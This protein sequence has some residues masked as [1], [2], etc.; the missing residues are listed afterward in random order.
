MAQRL[1]VRRDKRLEE[2]EAA[3]RE[4]KIARVVAASR[5]IHAVYQPILDLRTGEAVGVE[6]L[7][8]FPAQ[9]V[10]SPDQW[11]AEAA[12]VGLGTEVEMA[13]LR[14][15]LERLPRLPP[16]LYMSLNASPTTMMSPEFATMVAEIAAERIV[17]EVTEHSE[18][19]DYGSFGD[20]VSKLRSNGVRLAVDDAGAG[21][22]SFLHIL[23]VQP[24]IIKLDVA[25]T[26]GIDKDPARQALGSALLTF[27]LDAF[28]AGL[29]AEGIETERELTTLKA[30]GYPFGQGYHL[31]KPASA[32]EVRL[33]VH[34]SEAH[35]TGAGQAR[36]EDLLVEVGATQITVETD[37]WAE[38]LMTASRTGAVAG[39]E[40][41]RA[42]RKLVEAGFDLAGRLHATG[43]RNLHG[44]VDEDDHLA[45][46]ENNSI[47]NV[48]SRE[49]DRLNGR[50]RRKGNRIDAADRSGDAETD[51]HPQTTR[52]WITSPS[53]TTRSSVGDRP[54]R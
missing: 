38:E 33:Q 42:N 39:P 3:Q 37:E 20:S 51:R 2:I 54:P 15:A 31:G 35:M 32:A 47:R 40:R 50:A 41:L 53:R 30:L 28:N 46:S 29:I 26:R 21:F 13:A 34:G 5:T 6:A 11:F 4:E 49:P 27:G 52:L 14:V 25:L 8:R 1:S 16:G 12:E 23:N 18:V 48:R 22:S 43:H 44:Y 7:A 10:R 19:D 45:V 24:D 17:L 36:S 9:P